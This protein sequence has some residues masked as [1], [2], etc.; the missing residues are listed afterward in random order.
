MAAWGFMQVFAAQLQAFEPQLCLAATHTFAYSVPKSSGCFKAKFSS[1][2][3]RQN[4]DANR[5]KRQKSFQIIT[6][7]CVSLF[8]V[9]MNDFSYLHTNCFELSMY[10]GCDKFPHESELP[11]EWEN[12]RESLLVFMEQVWRR[13]S[14]HSSHIQ[15]RRRNA[16][17]MSHKRHINYDP[18]LFLD[19]ANW[20]LICPC[21]SF[22]W[23]TD[24]NLLVT[25]EAAGLKMSGAIKHIFVVTKEQWWCHQYDQTYLLST[26][27]ADRKPHK[28]APSRLY[29]VSAAPSATSY[30]L[31]SC[32]LDKV[33]FG[34]KSAKLNKI[35][36]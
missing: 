7:I 10:V 8:L 33:S 14:P 15:K 5:Q 34:S 1:K 6:S 22:H 24:L 28:S 36:R 31:R 32:G 11:E 12:N 2:A 9:G 30:S 4:S 20:L 13:L 17:T 19:Y 3:W 21:C 35:A 29:K 23:R 25:R 18:L 27:S 26:I 16:R